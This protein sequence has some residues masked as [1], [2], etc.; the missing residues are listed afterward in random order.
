EGAKAA[1]AE[2]AAT[3]ATAKPQAAAP[4]AAPNVEQKPTIPVAEKVSSKDQATSAPDK[5]KHD[6]Q[7]GDIAVTPAARR[8]L[9][10]FGLKASDIDSKGESLRRKDVL[11]Y[12]E[13]QK[14]RK[15]DGGA[16]KSS[17]PA[18]SGDVIKPQPT[19]AS[20]AT[21]SSAPTTGPQFDGEL[22][23]V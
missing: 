18:P 22:E 15:T 20:P 1:K 17:T 6:K 8:G 9:R 10:E 5:R 4:A 12:I 3:T 2:P 21:T 23:E 14:E 19:V 11:R 16:A 13:T 7:N